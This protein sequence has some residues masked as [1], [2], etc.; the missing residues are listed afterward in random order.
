MRRPNARAAG[1]DA[2]SNIACYFD[3]SDEILMFGMSGS[4]VRISK[5]MIR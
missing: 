2:T 4:C 5:E 3:V 1:S